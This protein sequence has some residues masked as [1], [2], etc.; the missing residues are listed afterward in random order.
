[1][2]LTVHPVFSVWSCTKSYMPVKCEIWIC[3]YFV[4]G[5]E[6]KVFHHFK[7][8]SQSLSFLIRIPDY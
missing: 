4:L 1:M 5:L 3:I 6:K 8:V 7:H 2:N